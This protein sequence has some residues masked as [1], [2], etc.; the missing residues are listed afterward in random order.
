MS[1]VITGATGQLGKLV[2]GSLLERGV[3]A[4]HIVAAGRDQEKLSAHYGPQGIRTVRVDYSDPESLAAA[5]Q[6]G[7]KV[8]LISGSEVGQR[9][10]QHRNVIDAARTAGVAQ[11]AYTSVVRADT[12]TLVLAPEHKATEEALVASGL[13]YTLLRNGWYTENYVPALEQARQTGKVVASVGNGRVASASRADYAAA[14]AAVLS[15][16]GHHNA[17]YELSGDVAWDFEELAASLSAALDRSVVYEAVEPGEHFELLKAAGLDDQTAGFLVALDG[18][19]R[20]GELAPTT[21]DLSRLTGRPTAS[22]RETIAQL[23]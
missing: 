16:D 7:D 10:A 20:D 19:I 8:L 12:S 22:L 14:A 11:L 18:N 15:T 3:E 9:V 4:S 21:G 13:P 2:I 1:I 23:S 5:F 6:S 17:V